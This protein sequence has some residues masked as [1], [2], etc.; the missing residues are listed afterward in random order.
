[1]RFEIPEG[2]FVN[3]PL[4]RPTDSSTRQRRRLLVVDDI[5]INLDVASLILEQMG[6]EVDR[7]D[8]GAQAVER[9][10]S[11]APDAVLMDIEM[12]EV[13]GLE[14]TRRLRLLQRTGHLSDFPII[15]L[16]AVSPS[17][18]EWREAGMNGFLPKPFNRAQVGDEIRHQLALQGVG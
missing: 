11:Q 14:A 18:V 8:G 5:P 7:A 4:T 6:Y 10:L 17:D 2:D 9:C 16:T 1:M 3:L 13:D 12:P 15:A